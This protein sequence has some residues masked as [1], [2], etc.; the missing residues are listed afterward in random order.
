LKEAQEAD[1]VMVRIIPGTETP[2]AVEFCP[3]E[4]TPLVERITAALEKSE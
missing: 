4:R 1:G 3:R 2:Y